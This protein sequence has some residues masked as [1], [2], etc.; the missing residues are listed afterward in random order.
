MA[1]MDKAEIIKIVEESFRNTVPPEHTESA[2]FDSPDIG[3][4]DFMEMIEGKDWKGFLQILETPPFPY[5]RFYAE[6]MASYMSH[7]ALHY[8]TPAYLIFAMD[9]EGCLACN[10][11][12]TFFRV[13]NPPDYP[14]SKR[15]PWHTT[16]DLNQ[17]MEEY[18]R[19]MA[20]FDQLLEL[21]SDQQKRAIALVMDYHGRM[22]H[23]GY[24]SPP[25]HGNWKEWIE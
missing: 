19:G 25:I 7:Q 5:A 18:N 13:I 22:M 21:Y 20:E 2:L 11:T 12:D 23:P 17:R 8:F 10:T 4:P 3:I 16:E 1:I 24:I 9:K 15:Y 6:E 14:S